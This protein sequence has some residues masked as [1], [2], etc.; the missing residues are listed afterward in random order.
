[1]N[2]SPKQVKGVRVLRSIDLLDSTFV[3]RSVFDDAVS[4]LGEKIRLE[5]KVSIVCRKYREYFNCLDHSE[6]PEAGSIHI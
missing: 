2:V 6:I 4:Y 3:I 5:A 1:M